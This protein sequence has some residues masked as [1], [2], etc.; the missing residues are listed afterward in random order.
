MANDEKKAVKTLSKA[1]E[2][3]PENKKEYLIGFAEGVVAIKESQHTELPP[4]TDDKK[5]EGD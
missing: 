1:F 5:K 3:L 4:D 2:A